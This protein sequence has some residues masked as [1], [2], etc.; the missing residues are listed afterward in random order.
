MA[1][2]AFRDP[3]LQGLSASAAAARRGGGGEDALAARAA[4]ALCQG[5]DP[6]DYGAA[7]KRPA[8]GLRRR[9]SLPPLRGGNSALLTAGIIIADVVGAGILS[10]GMAVAKFGW[11]MGSVVILLLL[12]MNVHVSLL[13]WRVRMGCPA[14]YTYLDLASAAFSRAPAW[15]R[16]GMEL[17]TAGLQQLFL[18]L[19]LA[20]YSLS[21]GRGLGTFFYA[22]FR[23]CLPLLVLLGLA[24][25]LPV[26]ISARSLGQYQSLIALNVLTIM[27]S[28]LIPLGH[29]A[30]SGAE[31]T[32][33]PGSEM[34]AVADLSFSGMLSGLEV[35][36][37]AFTSQFMLVEIMAEM[38][39][40]EQFPTAYMISAPFQ[41]IMFL[42]AGVGTYVYMGSQVSGILGENL[43]FGPTFRVAS[44]CLLIHMLI[45]FL[46]K[47]VVFCRWAQQLWNPGGLNDTSSKGLA[48]WSATVALSMGFSWLLASIVPFFTDLMELLGAFLTP[49]A[50]YIVPIVLYV[51]YLYDK[52]NKDETIGP[53][54]RGVL[55]LE[56]LLSLVL[57]TFGTYFAVTTIASNWHRY[58][59]PFEC[60]CQNI[61][62]T[63]ECS[64]QH[65]G[66]E[67]CPAQL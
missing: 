7:E 16:R 52:P 17:T 9:P 32:L 11:L 67:R 50:C 40:P 27:G 8:P 48:G 51:R 46:I 31:N 34:Q 22:E 61:W 26:H 12:S 1:A 60:H 36:S 6:E 15:Q 24:V 53:L 54:E 44:A 10:M 23:L 25:L 30:L 64:A 5:E 41:G 38:R 33:A 49:M 13:M 43:P 45:T 21:I 28:A 66:M 58:G 18:F 59:M 57:M 20:L 35:M 29:M 14:T 19:T 62:S 37:F 42:L 2:A 56:V 47:G 39:D 63:C 55:V 65:A 4:D 3:E